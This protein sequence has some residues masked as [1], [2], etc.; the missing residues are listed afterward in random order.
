MKEF[1]KILF[2]VDLSDVSAKIVPY[3]SNVAKKF[4][5]EIHLLFVVR[6]FRYYTDG[7]V[8]LTTIQDFENEAIAGAEKNIDEFAETHFKGH[9]VCTTKIVLGDASEEIINYIQDE[10]IDL[11]IMGTHGRKGLDRIL[12]GSVAERVIKMAPVPVMSVNPYRI[13]ES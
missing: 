3:V 2:P 11:V 10:N 4:G 9:P 8:G 5:A 13:S 12:F 7:Y 6:Q 1:K